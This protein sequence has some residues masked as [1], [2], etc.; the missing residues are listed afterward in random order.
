VVTR[1]TAYD[2]L[3]R[4]AF[5]SRFTAPTGHAC[6]VH[7]HHTEKGNP[8]AG[9]LRVI[10]THSGDNGCPTPCEDLDT[11]EVRVRS[12]DGTDPR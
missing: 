5:P 4:P 2:S 11:G 8:T 3:T 9:R 12:D 1:R 6:P 7:D 10:G